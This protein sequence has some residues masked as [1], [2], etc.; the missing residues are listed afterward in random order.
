M[1]MAAA[2][3]LMRTATAN[4]NPVFRLMSARTQAT[5]ATPAPASGS[6][7]D[8]VFTFAAPNEVFYNQAKNV[9]QVDIPTMSG[10][11]GILAHHVPILG[12]LKPGVVSVFE[13]DGNTKRFFEF[14][15]SSPA[16]IS[17][18]QTVAT[19]ITISTNQTTSLNICMMCMRNPTNSTSHENPHITVQ[20]DFADVKSLASRLIAAIH[21]DEVE[22]KLLSWKESRP[23]IFDNICLYSEIC[24]ILTMSSVRVPAQ[25]FLH[26]LFSD[27]QF[28]KLRKRRHH[29]DVLVEHDAEEEEEEEDDDDEEELDTSTSS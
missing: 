26:D 18:D 29:A 22:K 21:A 9:R 15:P 27:C 16:V 19:T 5:S 14:T 8:M 24:Y 28:Q 12:V 1:A 2:R 10:N 11:M 23:Q 6:A 3:L 4:R 20:T 25:R 13:Q 17:Q 7:A